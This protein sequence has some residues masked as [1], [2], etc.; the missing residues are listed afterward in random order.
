MTTT[1]WWLC[2][3]CGAWQEATSGCRG[4]SSSR[5]IPAVAVGTVDERTGTRVDG[6][7]V[8]VL[9]DIEARSDGGVRATRLY[10][11]RLAPIRHDRSLLGTLES[12]VHERLDGRTVADGAT[13]ADLHAA[14]R[15]HVLD[16]VDRLLRPRWP[17]RPSVSQVPVELSF[18]LLNLNPD[19]SAPVDT[20]PWLEV[21]ALDEAVARAAASLKSGDVKVSLYG[22]ALSLDDGGDRLRLGLRVPVEALVADVALC[23]KGEPST[24]LVEFDAS[25]FIARERMSPVLDVRLTAPVL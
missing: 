21:V 5:L 9:L 17:G 8:R 18:R 1:P 11:D 15:V 25:T 12:E 13:W 6:S 7:A 24:V 2:L 3:G 16:A 14:T 19:A 23:P 20:F 10:T 4:C 22:T